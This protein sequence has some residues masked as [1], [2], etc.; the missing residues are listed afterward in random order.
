MSAWVQLHLLAEARGAEGWSSLHKWAC[1]GPI[2][3][4][5][6]PLYSSRGDT[7]VLPLFAA[8]GGPWESTLAPE[9]KTLQTTKALP[10]DMAD[11]TQLYLEQNDP[12]VAHQLEVKEV[13]HYPWQAPIER[14]IPVTPRAYKHWED[15]GIVPLWAHEEADGIRTEE[16]VYTISPSELWGTPWLRYSLPRIR[17]LD[18]EMTRLICFFTEESHGRFKR[19]IL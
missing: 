11:R 8:L 2:L 7:E 6:Q 3:H 12:L 13:Q 18:A 4:P 19:N 16:V 10:D 15:T 14:C 9:R 1:S 5:K 17:A